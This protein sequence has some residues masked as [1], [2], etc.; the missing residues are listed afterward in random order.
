[1]P[2][3]PLTAAKAAM[4]TIAAAVTPSPARKSRTLPDRT[5]LWPD[6]DLDELEHPRR[7][8]WIQRRRDWLRR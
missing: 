5:R 6:D 7:D 3:K 2:T 8:G 1:M 4:K